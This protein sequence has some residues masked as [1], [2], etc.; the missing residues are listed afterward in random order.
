MSRG[1]FVVFLGACLALSSCSG[2]GDDTDAGDSS[3]DQSVDHPG[4]HTVD[5]PSSNAIDSAAE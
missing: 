4:D 1:V 2:G 3:A 5:G